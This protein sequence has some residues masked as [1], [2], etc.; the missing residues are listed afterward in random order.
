MTIYEQLLSKDPR[1]ALQEGSMHF[2]KQS[3]VQ[4]T[5]QKITERLDELGIPYALAGAMALFFHGYRRFTE[6]VDLL[7]TR[8]GLKEIHHQLEGLGYVP[9]F[10]GS[11]QLRDTQSGVRVEFLTTG[12][13]PGDGKPK[14]VSFP[15]PSEASLVIDGVRCLTLP[16]LIEL[17]IASG[18]S[19]LGR[20]K[21]LGDVQEVIRLLGL[22]RSFAEQL[23]PFVQEKYQELWDSV[24]N[25]PQEL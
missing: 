23:N 8:E 9:P 12:D 4:K 15:D 17:K 18:M 13:Y 19:N 24:Q 22:P 20:L 25:S 5:L 7:V 6:D 11:K 10:P 1:W 2:E 16:K 14:P 3:A 21:D